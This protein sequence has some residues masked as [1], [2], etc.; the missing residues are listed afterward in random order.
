M[1][2]VR[3]HVEPLE[4]AE[5]PRSTRLTVLRAQLGI[6]RKRAESG[7]RVSAKEL[8]AVENLARTLELYEVAA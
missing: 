1:I 2:Q 8:A 3:L 6:L 5:I 4:R 7:I